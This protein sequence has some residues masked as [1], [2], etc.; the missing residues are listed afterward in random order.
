M[1]HCPPILPLFLLSAAL[2]SANTFAQDDA[3]GT[4]S[5]SRGASAPPTDWIDQAT[6]HRVVRISRLA[7]SASLYFHQNVFTPEGDRMLMVTPRGLELV[8]LST[9][10]SDVVVSRQDYRMS[11]SSGVE[12]GRKSRSVYYTT[13]DFQGTVVRATHVDTK[14]TRDVARLPLGASLNGV[15]ADETMLFGTINERPERRERTTPGTRRMKFFTAAIETGE[16]RTFH[17]SGDWLNHGQCS[18]TDS[19]L[20]LFCHEG[21]W[22]DV[23]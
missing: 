5:A 4:E 8:D 3:S 17:P 7:G 21:T 13:R 15:N 23:D 2:L 18:P 20:A 11:G 22:Q 12:M 1:T 9:W 10:T 6:G 16:I 19:S 14:A